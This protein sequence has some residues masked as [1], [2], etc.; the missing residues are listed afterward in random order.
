MSDVRVLNLLARRAASIV[1]VFLCSCVC[2]LV[3]TGAVEVI[4]WCAIGDVVEAEK[5]LFWI[6]SFS[7][8]HSR[9][10]IFAPGVLCA[11][12]LLGVAV[13]GVVLV[14]RIPVLSL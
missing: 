9:L 5:T 3:V 14:H 6:F 11:S 13:V 8:P 10:F 2:D 1:H 4:M 7:V 12:M